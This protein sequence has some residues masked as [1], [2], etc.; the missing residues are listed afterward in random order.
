VKAPR[1][2]TA[3]GAVSGRR[4][5]IRKR[6]RPGRRL[7]ALTA[8]ATLALVS[9]GLALRTPA[10][11][12]IHRRPGMDVLLITIDTLRADAIGAYGREAGAT[13]W[14]DRLA[15]RGTVFT[16]ARAHNVV[17]LPSHANILSGRLPFEHGVRDNAGF[18]FPRG[19]E[20]LATRLSSRG[21]RTGAFVS[22]FTLES[23][24]GLDRGFDVYD[25]RFADGA[26]P[27]A[28]VLPERPGA[29]TAALAR[30]WLA[31]GDGKPS[32]AWVHLYDPH[33]PYRPPEPFAS[34]FA[35]DPYLGDVA[36][37]DAALEDLLAP[38]LASGGRPTLVV[39]TADH[40]ESLGEHGEKTHGVFAYESTLH[41]PLVL[42]APGVLPA[43]SS[44]A[45]VGHVDIVPTVLDALGEP[46]P[47]T[48]AGRSLL[49]LA[50]G[51][52]EAPRPT[53]F[54]A[55]SGLTNR[56]WAPLHGVVDGPAKLID[57]PLAELYA[58]DEDPGERRNLISQ[59]PH[60]RENLAA[61]LARFR[62]LDPG[63]QKSDESAETRERLAALGYL[64]SSAPP[65]A[66][67]FT[68]ADDPKRLIELDAML[69]TV[70]ARHR[71]GDVA[72]AL[73]LCEEVV[74][75]RPD[76]PAA[77]V[78]LALLNRRLGRGGAAADALRR[79][80]ALNPSDEGAVGLLGHY[81]NEDG[82]A[83]E[84]VSLL[85]P[86]ARRSEPAMDVLV[87]LG[88]AHS[89]LGRPGPAA[90]AFER[91]RAVDPS[92]AM[93]LVQ[94]ATARLLAGAR[95]EATAALEEA[96]RLNPRLAL[97]HHTL[98]LVAAQDGRNEE[99]ARRWQAALALDP[100]EHDALLQL[101]LL[102]TRQGRDAEARPYLEAFARSA[103]RAV[104]AREMA[105]VTAWLRRHD[106]GRNPLS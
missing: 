75:R 6:V 66:R 30:E 50:A 13:P 56:G 97:A 62:A 65:P 3:R 35:G 86:Y 94:L 96:L 85:E 2:A 32:F 68:S 93:V 92:N 23:R 81:L 82:Q 88:I 28:F 19:M 57:L 11:G 77:L 40:G 53:Y 38:L 67:R 59:R 24:F 16:N 29:A 42:F 1:V 63:V 84:A 4:D 80:V 17:T 54:E 60:L 51:A 78:Q 26:A 64:A 18:R 74:R 106:E 15:A 76:M 58:L 48:P 100:E 43:G 33:A 104:F 71:A 61:Q 31:A 91:A 102:L 55:L 46:A 27:A 45:T 69:E 90:A 14:I 39:L 47:E 34:R 22:A 70:I 8:A 99:A 105:Q 12:E 101:G 95:A 52:P 44:D 73:G 89:R 83:A 79:A 7:S 72:G 41:V 103:P 21:Y 10:R 5:P 87:A 9:L 36:T 20:T 49:P 37:A 98:G 25:D